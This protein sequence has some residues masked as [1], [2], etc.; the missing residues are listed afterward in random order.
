MARQPHYIELTKGVQS[1]NQWRNN[2]PSIRPSLNGINLRGCNL[3]GINFKD[4][5]L[6]GTDLRE[7]NLT[8][9]NLNWANLHK[10]D[11]TQANLSGANLSQA[12]LEKAILIAANLREAWLIGSDFEKAN[13]RDADLSKT[14]AA[15]ANFKNAILT[16]VCLHDWSID[17]FT[18][19]NNVACDYVYFGENHQERRPI[20]Y[21]QKFALGEFSKYF[22]NALEFQN[23]SINQLFDY[24]AQLPYLQLPNQNQIQKVKS[25]ESMR[26]W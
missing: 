6:Q 14:L 4:T 2:Y 5:D 1:W 10:A 12:F 20:H 16:G 8:Q 11:L 13:L 19:L 17:K 18:N 21:P 3:A 9:A 23:Q 26:N 7:A 15:K 22:K 25:F 24:S